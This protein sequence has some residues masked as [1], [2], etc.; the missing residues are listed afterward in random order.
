MDVYLPPEPY[1]HRR[2]AAAVVD[3]LFAYFLA[4]VVL[5]AINAA[6]GRQLFYSNAV[7]SESCVEAPATPL[8][9]AVETN[10]PL[11]FGWRRSIYLCEKSIVGGRRSYEFAV[12]D[13][14]Q[15]STRKASVGSYLPVNSSADQ[16]DASLRLDPTVLLAVIFMIVWTWR[17]GNSPGKMWFGLVVKSAHGGDSDHLMRLRRELLRLLPL[18]LVALGLVANSIA[19]WWFVDTLEAQL[20]LANFIAENLFILLAWGAVPFLAWNFYYLFPF[21]RWRGQT[22]YDRLAGTIVVRG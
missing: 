10:L 6:T 8:R 12:M 15:N 22:F 16:L 5:A 14:W 20:W 4:L 1:L 2:V 9:V 3:G 7:Y 19:Q 13:E 17:L 18:G 21:M 11:G